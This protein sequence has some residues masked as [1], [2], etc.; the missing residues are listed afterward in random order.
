[1]PSRLQRRFA[2]AEDLGLSPGEYRRLARLDTPQKIQQFLNAIPINFEVGGE[3]LLSVREVL[4]QRRAHCIEGAYV[5]A[6]ALWIHGEPPYV[7]HLDCEISDFPH[8]ITLFKRGG[9]WG[10][11]S[12]TN[13]A[14]LRYR[15][16][17]Y[18]TLRELAISYFHEYFNKRGKKTLRSYSGAFDLRR[19]DPHLWVTNGSQ[20]IEA[21]DR[22]RDL[23]H[24]DLISRRQEKLVVRRDAFE[25]SA[26]KML[27]WPPPPKGGR[28]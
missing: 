22:L 11:L 21:H 17:V 28:R 8:V 27:Q 14:Y 2:R 3:T 18:R 10:A 6:A 25:M 24:Y 15:D 9:C 20:C 5:A 1:M 13:G 7:M 12:K 4:K 16:P 19:M 23:R 26:S